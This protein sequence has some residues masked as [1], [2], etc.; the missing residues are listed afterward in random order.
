MVTCGSRIR[1]EHGRTMD[2]PEISRVLGDRAVAGVRTASGQ[3]GG[4]RGVI[5]KRGIK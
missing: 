4:A 3:A 2:P 5:E 1:M